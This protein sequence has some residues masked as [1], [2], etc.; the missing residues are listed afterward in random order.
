MLESILGKYTFKP[1][2]NFLESI[3]SEIVFE[4]MEIENNCFYTEWIELKTKL[5]NGLDLK[6]L[7]NKKEE[8]DW[9]TFY[10]N[11]GLICLE[12]IQFMIINNN[13]QEFNRV[14]RQDYFMVND[15]VATTFNSAYTYV[16]DDYKSGHEVIRKVNFKDIS[17]YAGV[18][19]LANF[20]CHIDSSN[21]EMLYKE[22][23]E[24]IEEKPIVSAMASTSEKQYV[25]CL[26]KY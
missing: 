9:I 16:D 2:I 7:I 12:E 3:K 11:M 13:E 17:H 5:K 15:D 10:F 1:L 6:I 8:M 22:D 18:D 20:S 21:S 23:N 24:I 4:E 14:I 19:N 25:K 26:K